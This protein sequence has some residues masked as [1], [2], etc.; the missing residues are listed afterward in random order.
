MQATHA[1]M[2]RPSPPSDNRDVLWRSLLDLVTC[3][4]CWNPAG[5]YDPPTEQAGQPPVQTLAESLIPT[6]AAGLSATPSVDEE[7]TLLPE[8]HQQ[9]GMQGFS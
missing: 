5:D 3:G 1:Q 6:G 7:A 4:S 8:R 2:D 9:G